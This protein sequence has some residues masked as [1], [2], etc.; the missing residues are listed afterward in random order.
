MSLP[1]LLI[2]LFVALCSPALRADLILP[3]HKPVDHVLLVSEPLPQGLIVVAAPARGMDGVEL[4]E[5]GKPIPF[6]GKYGTRL[7]ALPGDQPV[8]PDLAAVRAA[9][10]A[11]ADIPVSEVSSVPLTDPLASVVTTLRITAPA[12]NQLL[13]EVRSEERFDSLGF[14]SNL[15]TLLWTLGTV[16]AAGVGAIAL[17]R[18][19][20]HAARSA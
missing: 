11:S 7:Y 4:V 20:V 12:S 17:A 15:R 14:R 10:V 2:L 8:P 5:L 19:R 16:A 13:V 3:G 9:A 18:R 6:S 1:R